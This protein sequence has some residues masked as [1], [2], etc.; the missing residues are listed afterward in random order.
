MC[1][2]SLTFRVLLCTHALRLGFN[3]TILALQQAPALNPNPPQSSDEESVRA[4]TLAYGAATAA[5]EL[6]QMRGFW[7][8]QAPGLAGHFNVYQ[9]LFATQRIEFVNP[10]LTWL[11]ITGDQARSH[12]TADERRLDKQT[13]A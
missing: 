6:E 9:G 1:Y 7:N 3:G 4:L 5:G 2:M 11:E 13:G 10:K 8:P 12:L